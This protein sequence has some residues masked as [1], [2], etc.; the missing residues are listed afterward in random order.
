MQK[1]LW[2]QA[3]SGIKILCYGCVFTC[4]SGQMRCGI[5]SK[6]H[7]CSDMQSDKQSM[8]RLSPCF[9]PRSWDSQ[10]A[11]LHCLLGALLASISTTSP[12]FSKFELA[13]NSM[14][15]HYLLLLHVMCNRT[16]FGSSWA[17]FS[18][19]TATLRNC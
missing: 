3:S 12:A 15:L 11:N 10:G 16:R 1:R 9:T 19:A 7:A 4:L 14:S 13:V 17:T 5:G 18:L 6:T 8:A 2:L